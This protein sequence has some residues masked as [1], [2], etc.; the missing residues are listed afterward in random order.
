MKEQSHLKASQGFKFSLHQLSLRKFLKDML[1][2]S[3]R[4]NHKIGR[5]GKQ[6]FQQGVGKGEC[7]VIVKG[8]VESS[9]A[10]IQGAISPNWSRRTE[11]SLLKKKKKIVYIFII[12]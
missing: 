6:G 9:L 12:M 2:L 4:L 3:K 10:Q 11:R 1:C 5:T 7:R 8:G